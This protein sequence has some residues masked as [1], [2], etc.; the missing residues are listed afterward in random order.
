MPSFDKSSRDYA[1]PVRGS[2][3]GLNYTDDTERDLSETG[4]KLNSN[5]DSRPLTGAPKN[6]PIILPFPSKNNALRILYP[7]YGDI[8]ECFADLMMTVAAADSDLTLKLAIGYFTDNY[9]TAQTAYSDTYINE[10]WLKIRGTTNPLTVSEGVIA[11]DLLNLLPAMPKYGSSDFKND[12]FV[13]VVA[14]NRVPIS[15]GT[16]KFDYLNIHQSV[17]GIK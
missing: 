3:F 16:Y 5:P 10:S 4:S 8:A 7:H 12:G 6:S 14:F 15:T 13:L 11:A 1:V 17:T 2:I 9:F